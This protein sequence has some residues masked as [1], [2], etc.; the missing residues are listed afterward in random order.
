MYASK[1]NRINETSSV[2]PNYTKVDTMLINNTTAEMIA[3]CS[4]DVMLLQGQ[5]K[6]DT[7]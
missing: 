3:V 5:C 4:D 6:H 2:C 1:R 7:F